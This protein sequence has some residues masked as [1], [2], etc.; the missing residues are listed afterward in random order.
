M[1]DDPATQVPAVSAGFRLRDVWLTLRPHQW[2]KN[3][4]VLAPALAAHRIGAPG[5][6]ARSLLAL[7]AMT[8]AAALIYVINDLADRQA[9]R[10]HPRKRDRPIARGAVSTA[11]A[12]GMV[13]LLAIALVA[14][15]SAL[16]VAVSMWIGAYVALAFLYSYALKRQPIADVMVLAALYTLRILVGGAATGLPI[17]PWLLSFSMFLFFGLALLKRFIELNDPTTDGDVILDAR[18]YR[19]ADRVPVGVFGITS[20]FMG[21]VILALYIT[22]SDVTTLYRAPGWLWGL[23]AL[24][25]YWLCRVWLLAFRGDVHDDPVY[26]ALTDRASLMTA[27]LMVGCVFAAT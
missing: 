26:F 11:Q 1:N 9:D 13:L 21:V 25:G 15:L 8:L 18:G 12:L 27:A 20:G 4:L 24:L 10:A 23:C 6:A 17:S 14:T 19:P 3:V 22:G 5:V 2:I 16:P 7:L